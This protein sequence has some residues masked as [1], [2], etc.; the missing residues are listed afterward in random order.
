MRTISLLLLTSLIIV[1]LG[2]GYTSK[3]T[4]PAQPGTAPTITSL[5]PNNVS[6]GGAAFILTVNG[7][8]YA[9]NATVNWAGTAQTTTFVSGSQLTISVP[10]TAIATSATVSVTVTNPAVSGG[11]YGGGTTAATSSGM[12]FTIN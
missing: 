3:A 5:A 11:I 1:G 9:S 7:S 4:T 8:N 10:A 12:D 6:S 2:C